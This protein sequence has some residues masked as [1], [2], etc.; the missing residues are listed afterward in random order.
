MLALI[1]GDV[2][3]YQCGFASD[4]AA[5]GRG[6][7]H[8]ELA[9]CLHGVSET[10]RSVMNVSE[11]DDYVVFV[12]H[13]VNARKEAFPDYKANRDPT[14]KPYWFDEI[15]DYLFKHHGA[16]YSNEGDEADDA[17]GI[18]QCDDSLGET[19]ICTIDKDLDNVPGWHYNFSKSRKADGTYYVS[20]EQANQFFYKQILTGDSTDNIPGMYKKL[21]VKASKRF[22]SP[23][24]GMSTTKEMYEHVVNCYR[25]DEDW[26]KWVGDLVYIKRDES[27]LWL[28][29]S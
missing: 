27:G 10:I 24:E 4:A 26:V 28:P 16:M 5:R 29:K 18:A 19:I 21:G 23:L 12:S 14:H 7:A 22:T 8:E 2:L 9:F 13:P 6:E 15:G 20:E 3:R 1:D 11:A 25:G 17:M